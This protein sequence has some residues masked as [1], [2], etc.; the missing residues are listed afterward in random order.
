MAF[1]AGHSLDGRT[2]TGRGAIDGDQTARQFRTKYLGGRAL[3]LRPMDLPV[4]YELFLTGAYDAALRRLP[5]EPVVV[6][7][8]GH[9]GLFALRVKMMRPAA[10]VVS[11]EPAAANVA[12]F[13]QN[14]AGLYEVELREGAYHPTE[15]SVLLSTGGMGHNYRTSVTGGGNSIVAGIS[16]SKL[17]DEYRL[18][19][20]DLLKAN[21]E[22]AEGE[23]PGSADE[24][25]LRETR[26]VLIELHAPTTLR[27]FTSAF[28]GRK[29]YELASNGRDA[30]Y[31]I[32]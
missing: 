31:W 15:P 27:A 6:D 5:P 28:G 22:G 19:R 25:Y 12:V 13:S 30:A 20:V 14:T 2:S 7:L 26:Q 3:H 24:H 32:V 21:I 10:R 23:L 11:L 4:Y 29:V 16:L 8:G 17:L 18:D 1:M 9:V